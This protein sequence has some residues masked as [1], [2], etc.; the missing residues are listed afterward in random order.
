MPWLPA[1]GM[2][3]SNSDF[4]PRAHGVDRA[5]LVVFIGGFDPRGARHYYQLM[6]TESQKQAKV[7]GKTG[8][9]VGSRS[10]WPTGDADS[11]ET[12][13]TDA[14]RTDAGRTEKS[15]H[16]LWHIGEQGAARHGAEDASTEY[17]YFAWNDQVRAH[18]PE[19]RLTVWAQ[20]LGTY[21]AIWRLREWLG[22]IHV[23]ARFTLW[24]LA[25]PLVYA[26]LVLLLG[27]LA[28]AG[29]GVLAARFG[30][31]WS[32]GAALVAWALVCWGGFVLD[33]RIHVS[34]LLRIL[35]FA[36][37]S[38]EGSFPVLEQRIEAMAEEVA[39]GMRQGRWREVVVVGFSVGSVQAAKLAV[40]LRR[41]LAAAPAVGD[42]PPLSLLTLGNCI[43]LFGLFPGAGALRHTLRELAADKAVYWADI[44]SPSDSVCFGMCDIVGLSLRE[45]GQQRPEDLMAAGAGAKKGARPVQWGHN[46]QA[47]CSPRFHKLFHPTSYRWLRR[48]KMRMHFQYLMAGEIAGAYDYFALLTC[49][50]LVR[51]FVRKNLSR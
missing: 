3:V 20:A 19:S 17:L 26:A 50:G 31:M 18:W 10:R 9:V 16:S 5:R 43:P 33:G 39:R 32:A 22:P 29:A 11:A 13:G 48:N 34:W 40:A 2:N 36:R 49:P 12:G 21:A 24:A 42:E 7:A 14:G 25:Y 15:V 4:S 38:S 35:N 46:P 47:L 41:R 30:A 1:T 28:G 23:Q 44:S 37:I 45:E 27:V 51:D 8:Y 6:R